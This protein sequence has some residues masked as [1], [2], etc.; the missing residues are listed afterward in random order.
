MD[1]RLAQ[2]NGFMDIAIIGGDLAADNSLANSVIISLFSDG[3]AP[4]ADDLPTVEKSLRG[5]WF[6]TPADRFGSLLWLIQREKTT[7]QTCSKAEDYARRGLAWMVAEGIT[8]SVAVKAE[9]VD[10]STIKLQ[11]SLSRGTNRKYDQLWQGQAALY[12]ESFLLD[13]DTGQ[14][15][16][17]Q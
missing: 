10:R 4:S 12:S 1:V 17:A 6:D 2:L 7:Q 8:A 13:T 11:V 5:V 16:P 9:I 14:Y 15:S 3:R